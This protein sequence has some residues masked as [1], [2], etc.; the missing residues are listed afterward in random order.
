MQVRFCP[1]NVLYTA[2]GCT[3]KYRQVPDASG[4]HMQSR[5]PGFD[6]EVLFTNATGGGLYCATKFAVDGLTTASRHDLVASSNVR[7]TAVS[8][9]AVQTE[10]SNVRFGGDATKV[11]WQCCSTAGDGMAP[12]NRG[13]MEAQ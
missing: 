1:L 3:W 4:A 7:V 6:S 10:F 2:I 5:I 13:V 12:W 8:P 11:G 9:G